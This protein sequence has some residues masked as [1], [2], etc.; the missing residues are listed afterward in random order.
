[1]RPFETSPW[2]AARGF[3]FGATLF[4]AGMSAAHALSVTPIQLDTTS[5]TDGN[6]VFDPTDVGSFSGSFSFSTNTSGFNVEVVQSTGVGDSIGLDGT[7]SGTFFIGPV[8]GGTSAFNTADVDGTGMMTIGDTVSGILTAK[9]T[10]DAIAT[11]GS[12]GVIQGSGN[13]YDFSYSAGTGGTNSD[14]STL[15]AFPSASQTVTFQFK[16]P[17]SLTELTTVGGTSQSFSSTISAVPIPAAAW[18]FGSALAGITVLGRRKKAAL[19]S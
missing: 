2:A 9:V 15:A 10:F 16:S 3:A 11:F 6:V 13:M 14:L 12:G 18:L 19:A 8:S 7:L 1:M 5:V 17:T 4:V